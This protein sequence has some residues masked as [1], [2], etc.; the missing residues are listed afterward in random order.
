MAGRD[1]EFMQSGVEIIGGDEKRSDLEALSLAAQV[2]NS[3]SSDDV[4]LEI[5]DNTFYKLLLEKLDI[6]D[7]ETVRSL[8]ESKNTP[9]LTQFIKENVDSNPENA[10]IPRYFY[11]SPICSAVRRYSTRLKSCSQAQRFPTG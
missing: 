10:D 5:G 6:D 2:L 7:E 9:D 11:S 1:D 4:R 8:I 3:C